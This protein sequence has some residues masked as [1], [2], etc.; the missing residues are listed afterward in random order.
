MISS[1]YVLY[2]SDF[3]VD[4]KICCPDNVD[5]VDVAFFALS[6]LP[7]SA[8]FPTVSDANGPSCKPFTLLRPSTWFWVCADIPA[9]PRCPSLFGIAMGGVWGLAVSNALEN[10]PPKSVELR[11]AL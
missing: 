9:I 2:L 5:H 1:V 3:V 11:V 6:A 10:L 4:A 7:S 8:S